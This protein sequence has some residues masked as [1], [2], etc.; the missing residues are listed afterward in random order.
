MRGAGKERL[1]GELPVWLDWTDLEARFLKTEPVEPTVL[2]EIV[3]A[4]KP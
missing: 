4:L 3:K 2:D 1:S